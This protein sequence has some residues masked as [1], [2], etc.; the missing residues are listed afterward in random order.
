MWRDGSEGVCGGGGERVCGGGGGEGVCGGMVVR[1]CVEGVVERECVEG[2]VERE[3]VEGLV[4]REHCGAAVDSN[5]IYLMLVSS[6]LISGK[7][8]ERTNGQRLTDHQTDQALRQQVTCVMIHMAWGRDMIC[9][10]V[11]TRTVR[12]ETMTFVFIT[13]FAQGY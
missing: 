13:A 11:D 2:V 1:E 12:V 3:C 4:E 10:V 9:G 8:H 7:R 5:K 6:Q